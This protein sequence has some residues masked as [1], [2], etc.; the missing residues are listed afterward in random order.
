M[1]QR[2]GYDRQPPVRQSAP[3]HNDSFDDIVTKTKAVYQSKQFKHMMSGGMKRKDVRYQLHLSIE[4]QTPLV[5]WC[6]S[7]WSK[8]SP[9]RCMSVHLTTM[10]HPR[11]VVQHTGAAL[12]ERYKRVAESLQETLS[13]RDASE[14]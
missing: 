4:G 5:S 8:Y 10:L 3:T 1:A 14:V 2:Y 7:R 9:A 11:A 6:R 13:Q 12:L